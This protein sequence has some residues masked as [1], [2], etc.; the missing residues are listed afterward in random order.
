MK[1]IHKLL[2]TTVVGS[3][4][5]VRSPSLR[6]LFDPFRSAVETLRTCEEL[7]RAGVVGPE[8]KARLRESGSQ[9]A[10]FTD[11]AGAVTASNCVFIGNSA[12]NGG[13]GANLWESASVRH[14]VFAANRANWAGGLTLDGRA[15]ALQIRGHGA[16]D[17]LAQRQ[18]PLANDPETPDSVRTL[19]QYIK[20]A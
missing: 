15:T 13:G 19:V 4:P 8:A 7:R 20:G 9:F 14:C 6:S 10:L 17:G 12:V 18:E 16:P 2:P 3:Y 5:A 1:I 11:A